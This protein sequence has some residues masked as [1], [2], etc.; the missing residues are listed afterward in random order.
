M[1]RLLAGDA[2]YWLERLVESYIVPFAGVLMARTTSAA[3]GLYTIFP[4]AAM[5]C[6]GIDVPN[7]RSEYWGIVLGPTPSTY[8]WY[9]FGA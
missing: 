1:Y 6:S 8:I 7:G 3:S 5:I 4:P 2:K 9:T